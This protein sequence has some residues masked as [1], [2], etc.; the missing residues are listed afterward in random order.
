MLFDRY[1]CRG[2]GGPSDREKTAKLKKHSSHYKFL[3]LPKSHVFVISGA[4]LVAIGAGI[5]L[6]SASAQS[7]PPPLPGSR[8]P[9]SAPGGSSEN[10][11]PGDSSVKPSTIPLPG[12]GAG[13]QPLES[14]QFA[15]PDRVPVRILE[16]AKLVGEKGET[17]PKTV[18]VRSQIS[19]V[20]GIVGPVAEKLQGVVVR[21]TMTVK[22]L[23]TEGDSE[24]PLRGSE[25]TWSSILDPATGRLV[26][27]RSPLAS[28]FRTEAESVSPPTEVNAVGDVR[29]LAD[30][31]QTLYGDQASSLPTL[32]SEVPTADGEE[33]SGDEDTVAGVNDLNSLSSGSS[34]RGVASAGGAGL[35]SSTTDFEIPD[36]TAESTTES[37]VVD[38]IGTTSE[39]CPPQVDLL[40]NTVVLQARLTK[41]GVAEGACSDT[42]E[43]FTLQRS[44]TSCTDDVDRTTNK[45]YAR[46]KRYWVDAGGSSQF[47]DAECVRDA[48]QAFDL[49]EDPT[50]CAMTV[51]TVA[52]QA[53]PRAQ[54]VYTNRA[55]NKVVVDVCSPS[56]NQASVEIE[57]TPVGCTLRHDFNAGKSFRQTKLK[58]LRTDGIEV[59]VQECADDGAEYVHTKVS[60]ANVCGASLDLGAG[61]VARQFRTRISI[62]GIDQY[63]TEC[64]IDSDTTVA[65]QKD[66]AACV[67][68]FYHYIGSGQSHGSFKYYHELYGTK[69][70]VTADCQQDNGI[71]FTHQSSVTGYQHDDVT[72]TSMPLTRLSI[73]APVVGEVEVSGGQVRSDAV[74]VPYV[75]Q[76]TAVEETG[77]VQYDANSCNK[78]N[79]RANVST[80]LRADSTLFRETGESAT[81]TGPT[82][83]CNT[84]ISPWTK[85]GQASQSAGGGCN[86]WVDDNP[87][88]G[89]VTRCSSTTYS[90]SAQYGSS[91]IRVREDGEVIFQDS[92]TNWLSCGSACG[93][94]PGC[95]VNPPGS[96]TSGWEQNLGW[97]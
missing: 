28:S 62:D 77:E 2:L 3:C 19:N 67:N 21:G 52:L 14:Q 11:A 25:I 7:G 61:Q 64:A 9:L 91:V 57:R 29:S 47:V 6:D 81:P 36:T 68:T 53:T 51:D 78:Y 48:E 31:V 42:S 27:L 73:N 32:A 37:T 90:A 43:R 93:G 59:T 75:L 17:A 50:G 13:T 22:D 39:G 55:G 71:V 35:P 87:E 58:Y 92:G 44:Y 12:A 79:L 54:L 85:T 41:N 23:Q 60:D 26:Q 4:L 16:E 40:N 63:I 66:T 10:T 82:D 45:A 96:T 80:Y 56:N 30:A 5:A 49:V 95:P 18:R 20:P 76:S 65:L 34:G 89:P 1:V 33:G 72:K 94:A 83:G 70:T 24:V 8:P 38:N 46:Y 88:S 86:C 74:A 97:Q 15:W 84:T 69:Q